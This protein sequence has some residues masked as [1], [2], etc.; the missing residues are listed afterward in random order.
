MTKFTEPNRNTTK[1]LLHGYKISLHVRSRDMRIGHALG[2]I[3]IYLV[4]MDIDSL[5]RRIIYFH[6][7]VPDIE[8][9]NEENRSCQ[10]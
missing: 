4:S 2:M 5:T 9:M 3:H 1:G 10:I 6:H 7:I 8:D